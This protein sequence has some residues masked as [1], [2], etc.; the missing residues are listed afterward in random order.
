MNRIVFY[1]FFAASISITVW[2]AITRNKK[3][4]LHKVL[5]S[6]QAMLCGWVALNL[7]PLVLAAL[8][9]PR[10]EPGGW[11]TLSSTLQDLKVIGL[12]TGVVIGIAWLTIFLPIDLYVSDDSKLRRRNTAAWF[13]FFVSFSVAAFFVLLIR[14]SDWEAVRQRGLVDV[15]SELDSTTLTYVLGTCMTGTVAGYIRGYMDKPS[16]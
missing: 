1:S 3:T 6:L 8:F 14:L 16:F 4:F 2:L 7:V 15:I 13:G 5:R 10:A 12:C 9:P 11:K